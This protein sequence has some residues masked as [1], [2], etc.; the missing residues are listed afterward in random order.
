MGSKSKKDYFFEEQKVPT[1]S[2]Q[3]RVKSKDK[4]YAFGKPSNELKKFN[5]NHT[6]RYNPLVPTS[7]RQEEVTWTYRSQ[8]FNK[9]RPNTNNDVIHRPRKGKFIIFIFNIEVKIDDYSFNKDK[10]KDVVNYSD[11]PKFKEPVS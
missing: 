4:N 11:A 8:I 1:P 10:I 2:Y 3:I 7:K 9:E 6:Y 5:E